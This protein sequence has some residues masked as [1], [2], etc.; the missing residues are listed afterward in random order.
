MLPRRKLTFDHSLLGD[1]CDTVGRY[2]IPVSDGIAA[3]PDHGIAAPITTD[4]FASDNNEKSFAEE[5][6]DFW[7]ES[8]SESVFGNPESNLIP[9]TQLRTSDSGETLIEF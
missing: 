8:D 9:N 4:R 6:S 2:P 7:D 1:D 5:L 3:C